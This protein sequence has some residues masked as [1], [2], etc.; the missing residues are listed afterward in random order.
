MKCERCGGSA[1]EPDIPFATER[2]EEWHKMDDYRK[3]LEKEHWIF[4]GQE[5]AVWGLKTSL[6][7]ACERLPSGHALKDRVIAED[8]L[9][10][11]FRRRLHHYLP[12]VPEL[13]DTLEWLSLMQHYGAPTRL[14]D[15]TYS[16][17]VA[18]YF[19]L[20]SADD[21]CAVWAINAAWS[22]AT[23][24]EL[25]PKNCRGGKLYL[26]K[27]LDEKRSRD[28]DKVFMRPTP[29]PLAAAVNP[30]RL[31]ER[32]T[33]QKGV[34]MCPGDVSQG[35]DANLRVLEG[36]E[37]R[38]SVLKLVIPKE[39]RTEAIKDL[40]RLNITRASLF[41]GLDGFAQSLGVWPPPA[42]GDVEQVSQ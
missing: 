12:T 16:I 14:L 38:E 17:Y 3:A 10:R 13:S 33:V 6:E 35:F 26:T 23:S 28:F 25:L 5:K 19:A 40:F 2:L 36:Y 1:A 11:E 8:R 29:V 41:P 4:R 34:F 27:L 31:N 20:E 32:L 21:D 22:L 18:A 15:F 42:H 24:A 30:F 9:K 37:K 39:H 7:R